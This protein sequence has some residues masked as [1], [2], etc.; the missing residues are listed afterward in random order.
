MPLHS[1]P[2]FLPCSGPGQGMLAATV[3]S[4]VPPAPGLPWRNVFG[5]D[6]SEVHAEVGTG[7]GSCF[8]KMDK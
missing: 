8:L 1:F 6:P 3:H 5:G 4:A 7:A 2:L